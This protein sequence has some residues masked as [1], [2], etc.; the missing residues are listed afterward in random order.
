[1]YRYVYCVYLAISK[2]LKQ[3]PNCLKIAETSVVL[4]VFNAVICDVSAYTAIIS[5]YH[6]T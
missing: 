6:S 4:I 2:S 3:L 5:F 1:M